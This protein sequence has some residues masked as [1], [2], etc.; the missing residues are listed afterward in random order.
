MNRVPAVSAFF[1]QD[2]VSALSGVDSEYQARPVQLI[3]EVVNEFSRAESSEA[4]IGLI[5]KA[6]TLIKELFCG[7]TKDRV[8]CDLCQRGVEVVSLHYQDISGIIVLDGIRNLVSDIR[9]D[10]LCDHVCRVLFNGYL[11]KNQLSGA[12]NVLFRVRSAEVRFDFLYEFYK[13]KLAQE[14]E[15][16][17]WTDNW[18][19]SVFKGYVSEHSLYSIFVSRPF[20]SAMLFHMNKLYAGPV[21]DSEY[22]NLIFVVLEHVC[23]EIEYR[24]DFILDGGWFC[25]QVLLLLHSRGLSDEIRLLSE[26]FVSFS[27]ALLQPGIDSLS[28][29]LAGQLSL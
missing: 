2:T 6:Y 9:D 23:S 25:Q 5:G 1:Y 8:L 24:P 3:R 16:L 10:T 22:R 13:R 4:L 18:V 29:A 20:V 28:E 11:Q 15:V 21:Q 17:G 12:G 26:H 14:Q 27:L 7:V 19:D